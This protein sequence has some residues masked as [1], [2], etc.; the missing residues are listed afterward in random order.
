MPN[1]D[2]NDFSA[3]YN[4]ALSPQDE[5]AFQQWTQDQ[6]AK[7]GRNVAGDS[8]DYD[9]RGWYQQNGPQDLTGAHLTDEFKKPNHPTFSDQSRYNGV[10]G[11]QGGQ[12]QQQQGG[13]YSFTP[14]PTNVFSVPELQDYFKKVEPGNQLVVPTS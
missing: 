14:G 13:T 5:Q 11:M 6:S 9:L 8:Y 2:P 12:W 10:N 4:T 7:T 3:Q 1:G